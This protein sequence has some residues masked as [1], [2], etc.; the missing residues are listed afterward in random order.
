MSA[1]AIAIFAPSGTRVPL[2]S[3]MSV[4]VSTVVPGVEA[5]VTRTVAGLAVMRAACATAV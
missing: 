2:M 5:D 1:A 4:S 3:R